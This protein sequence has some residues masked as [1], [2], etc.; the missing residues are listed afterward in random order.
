MKKTIQEGINST[1][2]EYTLWLAELYNT[3]SNPYRL[4]LLQEIQKGKELKEIA[5]SLECNQTK[6]SRHVKILATS[7][8]I[9]KVGRYYRITEEGEK[10]LSGMIHHRLVAMNVQLNLNKTTLANDATKIIASSS[11]SSPNLEKLKKAIEDLKREIE[12]DNR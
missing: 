2:D 5:N 8:L 10:T 11:R 3:L 6:L 1:I 12:A 7:G 9:V 4:Y